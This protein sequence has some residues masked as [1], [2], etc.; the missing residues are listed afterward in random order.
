MGFL[1]IDGSQGEGGGQVLRTALSLSAC[2]GQAVHIRAIRSG[3]KKP[4]LMKQHLA[5]VNAAA[6][7][8]NAEVKGASLGS[9]DIE[10]VPGVIKAGDYRFAVGSAGSSTL[11]F[12]TVLPLLM[13]AGKPSHLLLEGGTHNPMAPTFDFIHEAFLPVLSRIGVHCQARLERYGFYPVGGGKWRVAIEA[14]EPF[15]RIELTQRGEPLKAEAVCIEAGL[16]EHV[17]QREMQRLQDKLDWPAEQIRSLH[18]KALGAGNAVSLRIY[19]GHVCE[20][21]DSIGVIGIRAEKVAS[22]AVEQLRCYQWAGAPVG[23]HLAD[24][25]LLPLVLA[26]GGS[27]VTGPLSE[28]VRTNIAVIK[29]FLDVDIQCEEIV[30]KRQWRIS[31][32]K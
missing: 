17:T 31:V 6:E 24:Q 12:Q 9:K 20:V 23:G 7:I 22:M 8:C 27:F 3:R 4:G 14:K 10:F 13:L 11:I 21:I 5:C 15:R 30:P 25:L 1:E 29:Q 26:A 19:Y 16:P 28:H 2:S 18:V 32:N